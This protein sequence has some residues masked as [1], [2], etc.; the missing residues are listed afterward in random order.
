MKL[1]LARYLVENEKRAPNFSVISKNL[2]AS[3]KHKIFVFRGSD[4]P[5]NFGEKEARESRNSLTNSNI[6]MNFTSLYFT[7]LPSR[8]KSYFGTNSPASA[9][10]FGSLFVIIPHDDVANVAIIPNDFNLQENPV[11][12][13]IKSGWNLSSFG[14]VVYAGIRDLDE[15]LGTP[16]SERL[17]DIATR[18]ST[19]TE[20][21]EQDF[22]AFDSAFEALFTSR[23]PQEKLEE[24]DSYDAKLVQFV[25]EK[26]S[27]KYDSRFTG[28][29]K[30]AIKA[31]HNGIE[32]LPFEQALE[33]MGTEEV[34]ELWFEGKCS[35]FSLDWLNERYGELQDDDDVDIVSDANDEQDIHAAVAEVFISLLQK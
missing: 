21:T 28:F 2:D 25:W 4:T 14:F 1:T 20:V 35:F 7:H 23:Q 11:L 8:K 30:A 26:V 6:V 16:E 13:E 32:I 10:D 15:M 17:V 5:G 24:E 9:S 31:G 27:E 12:N 3:I 22:D 18:I 19:T 34:Y 29:L 33:K